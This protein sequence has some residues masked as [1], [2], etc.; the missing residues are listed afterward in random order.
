MADDQPIV[1]VEFIYGPRVIDIGDM[2]IAR[3]LT[4]RPHSL[5]RHTRLVWDLE[6]RRIFCEDCERTVE[7]FDAFVSLVDRYHHFES[8]RQRMQEAEQHTL[9]SRAAK[10]MDEAFRSR[11]SAPACPH[12]GA[13]ILPEDVVS[14]LR[15][16]SREIE[17]KRRAKNG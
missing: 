11:K 14:G 17:M 8:A 2:R 5:C 4:R 9:I 3:G 6:E 1:P 15:Q 7:A 13:A 10:R 16:V 12:C